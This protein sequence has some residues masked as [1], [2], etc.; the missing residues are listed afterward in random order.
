MNLIQ[1]IL[2]LW[3]R[4]KI[5]TISS[6]VQIII[7]SGMTFYL[8]C[9]AWFLLPDST[10]QELRIAIVSLA[11]VFFSMLIMEMDRLKDANRINELL[12]NTKDIL[13]KIDDT[14]KTGEDVSP[15]AEGIY[16]IIKGIDHIYKNKKKL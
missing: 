15:L 7:L 12:D 9:L 14:Q 8:I 10:S 2:A 5:A 11:L 1:I 16:S 4:S 6:L 13:K 3:K